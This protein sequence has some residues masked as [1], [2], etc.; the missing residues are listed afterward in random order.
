MRQ[1]ARA[2]NQLR[3]VEIIRNYTKHASGSVLIKLGDTHVLVTASVEDRVPRHIYGSG[4]GWLTAEYNMLPS[5]TNTRNQRERLKVSGRTQEIQRLIGRSLRACIDLSLLGEKTITIDADVIQADGGTRT[6][7]ITGGYIALMD[8]C[9]KLLA[10]GAIKQNPIKFNLAAISVG[11]VDGQAVL[12]LPYEED[13][14]AEV[15]ANVVMND[16]LEIIEF[17]TSSESEP[18]QKAKMLEMLELA[19]LGIT[20]L[21]KAQTTALGLL[22]GTYA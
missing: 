2:N 7:S 11:M 13:S 21:I 10:S 17:Q 12:D 6:A 18:L 20:E 14:R 5:A 15:D 16:K 19:E 4:N 9:N 1:D 22:E 3:A 8:A